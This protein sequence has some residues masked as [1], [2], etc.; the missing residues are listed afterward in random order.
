MLS[1]IIAFPKIEDANNI[2][3]L[4]VRNGYEVTATVTSGAQ[5]IGLANEMDEGI[6]ICGYRLFDMLY[7]EVNGYL[8]KGFEMLLLASP[9]RLSECTERN[10]V[11]LS[12]PLKVPDLLKTLE[13]M[14]YNYMRRKKKE[15]SQPKVRS[16][17]EK[18]LISK[19]KL[20]LIQRN[21]MTEEE[22]H[23]YIQ[24]TSMDSGINLV[25]MAEMILN[26]Y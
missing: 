13:L 25:E 1:I 12:M 9:M 5:A 10:L 18:E 20:V 19:A 21:N 2:K 8:P 24:K 26:N 22:A 23:R 6:V 3:R 14:T 16:E 7:R 15:R 11:S 4:L 17:A